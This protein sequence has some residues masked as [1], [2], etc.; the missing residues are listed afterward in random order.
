MGL[1]SYSGPAGKMAVSAGCP[2]CYRSA[3]LNLPTPGF[4]TSTACLLIVLPAVLAIVFVAVGC[5]ILPIA[6][7]DSITQVVA[8]LHRKNTAAPSSMVFFGRLTHI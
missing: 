6:E 5:S 1:W 2:G 4:S 3:I 7:A 8:E